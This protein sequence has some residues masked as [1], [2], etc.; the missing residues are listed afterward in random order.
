MIKSRNSSFGLLKKNGLIFDNTF[1]IK[2]M[3]LLRSLLI[4]GTFSLLLIPGKINAQKDGGGCS[5]DKKIYPATVVYAAG[6]DSIRAF[7]LFAVEIDGKMDTIS[8]LSEFHINP[9]IEVIEQYD[10]RV[11]NVF[12]YEEWNIISG[13]CTPHI[14]RLTLDKYEKKSD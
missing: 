8:Y 13:H 4:A 5:Y 14:R 1:K 3:M 9:G 10:L 7:I 12:C 11:G 2:I 6:Y